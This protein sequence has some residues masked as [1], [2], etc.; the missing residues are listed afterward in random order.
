M[1]KPAQTSTSA[2]KV[3]VC[4]RSI[5]Q[6]LLD[7]I[8]VNAMRPTM[9]EKQMRKRAND[10]IKQSHT[11]YSQINTTFVECHWMAQNTHSSTRICSMLLPWTL[12]SKKIQCTSAMLMPKQST[13]RPFYHLSVLMFP[14]KL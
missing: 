6:T 12:T 5:A 1:A 7:H 14:G 8:T 10:V 2:L 11:C 3:L 4:A 9:T 13:G